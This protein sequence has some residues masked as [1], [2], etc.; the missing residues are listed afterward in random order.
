MESPFSILPRYSQSIDDRIS[1]RSISGSTR[2]I[3]PCRNAQRKVVRVVDNRDFENSNL[4]EL[5]PV[6]THKCS[7]SASVPAPN[8]G[9]TSQLGFSTGMGAPISSLTTK[10]LG[11][12]YSDR[13]SFKLSTNEEKIFC[14]F[15]YL[16]IC[17]EQVLL[18]VVPPQVTLPFTINGV[19]MLYAGSEVDVSSIIKNGEN[20]IVFN[21]MNNS[22]L[23]VAS[24]QWRLSNNIN[25]L[26]NEIV[27]KYPSM[28]ILPE[29]NFV[30]DICPLSHSQIRIA[31]RGSECSHSQCF[32]LLSFLQ[33]VR[34]SNVWL[35]PICGKHLSFS[36]LR[37]DPSFL[38]NCESL[39]KT[40][41]DE[42]PKSEFEDSFLT[43]T[44]QPFHSSAFP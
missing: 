39:F 22:S 40:E 30:T 6:V 29:T 21:T 8:S 24:I 37:H 15:N 31:S 27:K 44:N 3:Y 7:V 34:N 42:F 33:N 35:C 10:C 2:V 26:A 11:E 17:E 20:S 4:L 16:P 25:T 38:K 14:P 36:Q 13:I 41:V 43:L 19:V 12:V 28:T 5:S 9:M 18:T 23:I 32:D 1:K